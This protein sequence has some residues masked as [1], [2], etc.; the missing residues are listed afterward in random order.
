MFN[1]KLVA[2]RSTLSRLWP[3]DKTKAA[4]TPIS[5]EAKAISLAGN[6]IREAA[7]TNALLGLLA[8]RLPELAHAMDHDAALRAS[9]KAWLDKVNS[10]PESRI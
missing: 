9:A 3:A 8:E 10:L 7:K 1:A 5:R 4:H 6:M 2:A